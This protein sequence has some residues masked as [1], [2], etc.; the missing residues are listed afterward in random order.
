MKLRCLHDKPRVI[1]EAWPGVR[2]VSASHHSRTHAHMHTLARSFDQSGRLGWRVIYHCSAWVMWQRAQP[3]NS[4][5]LKRWRG[6][7]SW[8]VLR[9]NYTIIAFAKVRNCSICLL[10]HWWVLIKHCDFIS[11][12]FGILGNTLHAS[13][14]N[15]CIAPHCWQSK[16]LQIRMKK[17]P[18]NCNPSVNGRFCVLHVFVVGIVFA[19]FSTL[20]ICMCSS[21]L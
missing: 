16:I 15:T 2:E 13:T 9:L 19:R 6:E 12:I 7:G 20:R 14:S 11:F 18:S 5:A 3:M 1:S 8:R 21:L 17:M 10:C 4:T